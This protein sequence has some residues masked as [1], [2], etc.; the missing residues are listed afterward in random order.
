MS[1]NRVAC[2]GVMTYLQQNQH[3]NETQAAC[4]TIARCLYTG[5]DFNETERATRCF[6]GCVKSDGKGRKGKGVCRP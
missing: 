1:N 3:Y 2:V 6:G 4:Q 5:C